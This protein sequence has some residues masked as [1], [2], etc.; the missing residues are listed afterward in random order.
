MCIWKLKYIF[1]YTISYIN[2]QF[3]TLQFLSIQ[4]FCFHLVAVTM[5]IS[6]FTQEKS[7][8][9]FYNNIIL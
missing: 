5:D 4:S 7:Y 1:G 3:K 6:W 2:A 9:A 8:Y